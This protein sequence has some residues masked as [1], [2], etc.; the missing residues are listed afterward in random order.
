MKNQVT[1]AAFIE[2]IKIGLGRGDIR[3]CEIQLNLPYT[4]VQGWKKRNNVPKDV[5]LKYA[6]KLLMPPN[7]HAKPTETGLQ[8]SIRPLDVSQGHPAT[9]SPA[10]PTAGPDCCDE[11]AILKRQL[12]EEKRVNTELKGVLKMFCDSAHP[13]CPPP[14]LPPPPPTGNVA[15]RGNGNTSPGG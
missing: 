2:A 15:E 9:K 3:K 7:F 6:P 1:W 11:V 4:T 14:Y 5:V 12:E 8:A 13:G 10:A